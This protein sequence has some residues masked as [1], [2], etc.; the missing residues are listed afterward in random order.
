M[1]FEKQ[2]DLVDER[3]IIRLRLIAHAR[4]ETALDVVLQAR[5][6]AFAVDRLATGAQREHDAHEVDQFAQTRRVRVRAEVARTVVT[7]DAG[8]D[9]ARERLVRYLEIGEALVVA[10]AHVERRLMPLD[11]V[12]LE[13]QRFDLVRHDDR[14]HVGDAR[15]HL[16][17]AVCVRGAVLEV[18]P[19]AAAQ[20]DGLPDIENAAVFPDHH[21][22]AGA[23]GELRER[24][25]EERLA[26]MRAHGPAG[27]YTLRVGVV[28]AVR[29]RRERARI[30]AIA[31]P[32]TTTKPATITSAESCTYVTMLPMLWPAA[33]PR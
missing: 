5:A 22:D 23:V 16:L 21:V 25:L 32:T 3:V 9:D 4:R 2:H 1:A 7:H 10:Q 24:P 20:R 27:S 18:R 31:M 14:A 29:E 30:T 28:L 19:H 12:R 13:D 33:L 8:E 11:Q 15:H 17:R 6:L 26:R